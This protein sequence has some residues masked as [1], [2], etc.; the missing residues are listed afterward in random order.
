M[1]S[2]SNAVTAAHELEHYFTS[3]TYGHATALTLAADPATPLAQ[4]QAV[5]SNLGVDENASCGVTD[6]SRPAV[7]VEAPLGPRPTVAEPQGSA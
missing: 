1:Q 7:P 5:N 6:L 4:Q 2:N 3:Q